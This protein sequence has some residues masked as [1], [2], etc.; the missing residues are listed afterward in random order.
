M[1]GWH[2]KWMWLYCSSLSKFYEKKN[3][4]I[5]FDNAFEAKE[6]WGEQKKYCLKANYIDFSHARNVVS[7]KLWSQIVASRSVANENLASCPNYGAV[8]GFPILVVINGEYQGIYTFNIPKDIWCYGDAMYVMTAEDHVNAT[9]FKEIAKGDGSDFEI[10]YIEDEKSYKTDEYRCQ[11]SL[12]TPMYL[13]NKEYEGYEKGCKIIDSHITPETGYKLSEIDLKT[14]AAD[15][16]YYFQ[17]TLSIPPT[18][19]AELY[20]DKMNSI[21]EDYFAYT[22]NPLNAQFNLRQGELDKVSNDTLFQKTYIMGE[23]INFDEKK[24]ENESFNLNNEI[25]R[26][27]IEEE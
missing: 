23:E 16:E 26:I 5:K 24:T 22:G 13:F 17:F 9:R 15:R 2:R 21:V 14:F 1:N 3:Y 20:I 8:D 27:C 10:E 7:A 11:F 6:G 18:A 19:D 25:I 12:L 4:T